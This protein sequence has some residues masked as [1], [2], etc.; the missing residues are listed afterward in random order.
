MH[1]PLGPDE[2]I[3]KEVGTFRMVAHRDAP[4]ALTIFSNVAL[5]FKTAHDAEQHLNDLKRILRV[6]LM[7]VPVTFDLHGNVVV[8]PK[9][10]PGMEEY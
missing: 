8:L 6:R 3:L 2:Y 5:R 10:E 7:V 1:S 9:E 4:S